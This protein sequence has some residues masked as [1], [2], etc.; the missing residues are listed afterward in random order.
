MGCALLVLLVPT[1]AVLGGAGVGVQ[2]C[3]DG[4]FQDYVFL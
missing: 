2:M 4:K 1:P 3:P